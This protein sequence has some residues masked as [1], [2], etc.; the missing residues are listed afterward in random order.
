MWKIPNDSSK[1]MFPLHIGAYELLYD[2]VEFR[3]FIMV[4]CVGNDFDIILMNSKLQKILVLDTVKLM[5]IRFKPDLAQEKYCLWFI[6][7]IKYI[8]TFF[9]SYNQLHNTHHIIINWILTMMSWFFMYKRTLFYDRWN[10]LDLEYYQA[11]L[12]SHTCLQCKHVYFLFCTSLYTF[13]I[14]FVLF[15]IM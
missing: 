9:S 15:I 14:F 12:C 6:C 2:G 11:F 10:E 8:E 7:D 4:A 1:L 5:R 13:N 3:I